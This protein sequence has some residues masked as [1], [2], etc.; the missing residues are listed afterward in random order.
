MNNFFKVTVFLFLL[1]FS[2]QYIFAQ[3]VDDQLNVDDSNLQF[4]ANGEIVFDVVWPL[5]NNNTTEYIF[6]LHD[7]EEPYSYSDT[8]S[9]NHSPNLPQ[10][11]SFNIIEN[12]SCSANGGAFQLDYYIRDTFCS[13]DSISDGYKIDSLD[14]IIVD[15]LT[16]AS[17]VKDSTCNIFTFN[18][19]STQLSGASCNDIMPPSF[20]WIIDADPLV[21]NLLDDSI[22]GNEN[23]NGSETI[24]VDFLEPGTYQVSLIA[25]GCSSDIMTSSVC[26]QDFDFSSSELNFEIPDTV[27]VDESITL[28]NDVESFINCNEENYDL[29]WT[30]NPIDINC[31]TDPIDFDPIENLVPNLSFSNPGTYEIEFN[32]S[33]NCDPGLQINYKDTILVSGFPTI[34]LLEYDLI[35]NTLSADLTVDLDTTSCFSEG[36]YLPSWEISS[37][38]FSSTFEDNPDTIIFDD[39]GTY[40]L[41]YTLQSSCGPTSETYTLEINSLSLELENGNDTVY[42]C[43]GDAYIVNSDVLPVS[44][45]YVYEWIGFPETTDSLPFNNLV[46]DQEVILKVT[47]ADGCFVFDTLTI[48]VEEFPDVLLVADTFKCLDNDLFLLPEISSDYQY[49][50]QWREGELGLP[51]LS[52]SFN[53]SENDNTTIYLTVT[54]E[55]N[56]ECVSFDSTEVVISIIED[57]DNFPDTINL[58]SN[59]SMKLPDDIIH[60]VISSPGEWF[61]DDVMIDDDGD[62]AFTNESNGEFEIYYSI[63]NDSLCSRVDTSLVIVSTI[64]VL[65]FDVDENQLCAPV[66]TYIVFDELTLA[67]PI[68]TEYNFKIYSDAGIVVEEFQFNENNP[69]PDTLFFE[70]QESSCGFDYTGTEIESIASAGQYLIKG[71]VRNDCSG[72]FISFENGNISVSKDQAADFDITRPNKCDSIY[73][74]TNTSTGQI[75]DSGL[76]TPSEIKWEV[77]GEE[78]VH[79]N[80][81]SGNLDSDSGGSELLGIK[82]ISPGTYNINLIATSCKSDTTT[83]VV[84]I[85][86]KPILGVLSDIDSLTFCGPDTA[87]FDLSSDT[88]ENSDSTNY[89][90]D[91]YRGEELIDTQNYTQLTLPTNGVSLDSITETSCGLTYDDT[92]YNG[93]YRVEVFAFNNKCDTSEISLRVY[94]NKAIEATYTIDSNF[95][96]DSIYTFVNTTDDSFN[97]NN[98]SD[99]ESLNFKWDLLNAQLGVDY[100]VDGFLGT[101]DSTGSDTLKVTFLNAAEYKMQLIANSPCSVDTSDINSFI[102]DPVVGFGIDSISHSIDPLSLNFCGVDTP[103]VVLSSESYNN[104]DTMTTYD[105]RVYDTTGVVQ[106]LFLQYHSGFDDTINPDTFSLYSVESNDTTLISNVTVSDSILLDSINSSSCEFIHNDDTNFD[107][108]YKVE[109][110]AKNN[111][112]EDTLEAKIFFAET[113]QV[114][115]DIDDQFTCHEDSIY[116]FTNTSIGSKNDF[117]TC[118]DPKIFWTINGVSSSNDWVYVDNVGVNG[119][120]VGNLSTDS[121]GTDTLRIKFLNSGT[122]NIKLTETSCSG[123]SSYSDSV[124]FFSIPEVGFESS[125]YNFCSTD[126]SHVVLSDETLSNP[127]ST[128]Y[129]LF[130]FGGDEII[131]SLDFTQSSLPD[132]VMLD[133]ITRS[134]CVFNYDDSSFDGAYK[135]VLQAY[136]ICDLYSEVSTKVYFTEIITTEFSID[137]PSVCET[138]LYTFTN[139]T[140]SVDATSGICSQPHFYW[141]LSGIEDVNLDGNGDW[142]VYSGSLGSSNTT[143]SKVLKVLFYTGESYSSDVYDISL[144]T[145]PS[146]VNDDT[147]TVTESLCVQTQLDFIIDEQL[148]TVNEDNDIFCLDFNDT[149]DVVN[150][151]TVSQAC[152]I[153]YSWSVIP[154]DTFCLVNNNLDFILTK[155]TESIP[156]IKFINP[157]TYKVSCIISNDCQSFDDVEFSK[158][159]N[160]I[161]APELTSFNV[162]YLDLCDSNHISID[163]SIDTCADGLYNYGWSFDTD[164]F[165]SNYSIDYLDT[166]SFD[167]YSASIEIN[168][169][170]LSPNSENQVDFIMY[171]VQ[172]MCGVA[173][174]VFTL[175]TVAPILEPFGPDLSFCVQSDYI[176]ELDNDSLDGSWSLDNELLPLD[177]LGVYFFTPDQVG[178][179]TLIYSYTDLDTCIKNQSLNIIVNED[180][181][182]VANVE[183]EVCAGEEASW[184]VTPAGSCILPS[185]SLASVTINPTDPFN[186]LCGDGGTISADEIG[187]YWIYFEYE[188][189]NGDGTCY[190]TDSMLFVVNGPDFSIVGDSIL[191]DG[192]TTELSFDIISIDEPIGPVVWNPTSETSYEIEVS[193]DEST[194]YVCSITDANNCSVSDT[195]EL[196]VLCTVESLVD[197][198]PIVVVN[199]TEAIFPDNPLFENILYEGCTG[200]KITFLKPNCINVEDEILIQ[201]KIRKNGDILSSSEIQIDTDFYLYPPIEGGGI[202]IPSDSSSVTLEFFTTND[203]VSE[204]PDTILFAINPITY[205]ECV[206]SPD[207]TTNVEFIIIDQPDFDV[208]IS[209]NPL[210]TYCPGDDTFIEAV[211]I[212]GV[213]AEM[214]AQ[215][216][217][218]NMDPYIFEWDHVGSSADQLMNPESTTTFSVQVT[219]ICGSIDT[220]SVEVVV[221]QYDELLAYVDSTHVCEDTLAKICVTA[222]GGDGNYNYLWSNEATTEC[223]EEYSQVDP[224]TVTVTDGCAVDEVAVGFIS[225]GWPEDPYFEYVPLPNIEFGV[226]FYNYTTNIYEYN[227]L[228]DFGDMFGSDHYHPRH[229]YPNEGIYNVTLTVSDTLY[230]DCYREYSSNVKVEPSFELWV[231]NSFTPNNDGVND[232]F[233]PVI[234]GFDYY[235]LIITNRWGEIVFTSIDVSESWDGYQD[236]K[237]VPSGVYNCEVIYSKPDDIMKLSHYTNINLI[238]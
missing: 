151:L 104:L 205:S 201:Y 94:Y 235:E 81:S 21:F 237:I 8:I 174:S 159:I 52:E 117:G 84:V 48:I 193:P 232:L 65:Y 177:S 93:A 111:C 50:L 59:T 218:S 173:D 64:P 73:Q 217:S 162:N 198:E 171:T 60:P 137:T 144:V 99:C 184:S 96:C 208:D 101:S 75:N 85:D 89:R 206:R 30:I 213:G 183:G 71:F 55:S 32:L 194:T 182:I 123:S 82:F 35:C 16:V 166:V 214:I 97:Y 215:S 145:I 179:F 108:A 210:I 62:Y 23:L 29:V 167:N 195:L 227:Y 224:Y 148:I 133:S 125:N 200:A 103:F 122:Y 234:I 228:W 78:G 3:C 5:I 11:L 134:S 163:L 36:P 231:P 229:T 138:A 168:F 149:L 46:T 77:S 238:R 113:V 175:T 212:G 87:F 53:Y 74:F 39:S 45:D 88:Y 152:A 132:T 226:E 135:V 127:D 76:C 70:L 22:L 150:N 187:E 158:V 197:F 105:V 192:D 63:Q 33:S 130:L 13:V 190:T 54:S 51:F 143:G 170:D 161:K 221:N 154:Q 19:T 37:V 189:G 28:N 80:V 128:T 61:G 68:S 31:Q 90:V 41:E 83:K 165:P 10:Q 172:N 67:N 207:T 112:I 2:S 72:N 26:V 47:N 136:N 164:S 20:Y 178:D 219:D 157:G 115:F 49:E 216:S 153:N 114:N 139:E 109:L 203:Y 220:A 119:G 25:S 57:Y 58:C 185:S 156:E 66:E 188:S 15:G 155:E 14:N 91:V 86:S 110:L 181:E 7:L 118:S 92:D 230:L 6:I 42:V 160:V 116:T 106:H 199:E 9:F 169:D 12:S 4:C 225:K 43:A 56:A 95:S 180:P 24:F 142:I 79:W 17:F 98:G 121:S 40:S 233:K 186:P 196:D 18:N 1:P 176:L 222:S 44:S 141:D 126:I 147:T 27:C 69:L 204:I 211:P 131:D 107:G 38:G 140:D 236:G 124:L 202:L 209:A 223:I 102:F 34:D 120:Y 191:C 146:C 100:L 129:K